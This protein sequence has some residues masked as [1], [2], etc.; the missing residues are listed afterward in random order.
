MDSAAYQAAACLLQLGLLVAAA[1]GHVHEDEIN[2]I[3]N[4]LED[5]FELS[6][7][8][9]KRL[10]CLRLFLLATELRDRGLLAA[11]KKRLSPQQRL[12]VGE[13]LVGV[14][15]ADQVIS[16]AEIRILE[17]AFRDLDLPQ[18]Q[19]RDLL[20]PFETARPAGPDLGVAP[21][22]AT[23]FSLDT[24]AIS[25][26]MH[27]TRA[28]AAILQEAMAIDEDSVD[29]TEPTG[30]PLSVAAPPSVDTSSLTGD[31]FTVSGFDS[32]EAPVTAKEIA[33]PERFRP[34]FQAIRLRSEW[35][36]EEAK[37]LA[38]T[39]QVMLSGAIEAINEWA[40]ER[41]GDWLVEEG[42]PL[43]IRQDLL[44]KD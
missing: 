41:W 28:V 20:T 13:Y 43:V 32:A 2:R 19:L 7:N 24:A 22:E 39:H 17:R 4:H 26:I 6:G 14:A 34:F 27:D 38:R 44:D 42:N 33:L 30:E 1:D 12:V 29:T 25:R 21:A 31:T 16:D 40:Q 15:A 3:A 11:L 5:Q 9:V 37:Q 10:E 23:T 18:E 8:Q 35:S 36:E